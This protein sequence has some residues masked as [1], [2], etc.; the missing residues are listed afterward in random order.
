MVVIA[1]LI[2][3]GFKVF[4][5]TVFYQQSKAAQKSYNNSFY[6]KHKVKE[7]NNP[8]IMFYNSE[9]I[10]YSKDF[11]DADDIYS[12]FKADTKKDLA[13]DCIYYFVYQYES[14]YN[15]F[16]SYRNNA[17]NL[18][19]NTESKIE[20]AKKNE[21]F[22][23]R[24]F[25]TFDSNIVNS[26]VNDITESPSKTQPS[27]CN[28]TKTV[29]ELYELF[30]PIYLDKYI[31]SSI[32]NRYRDRK[33]SKKEMNWFN[34][35]KLKHSLYFDNLAKENLI[36]KEADAKALAEK[37]RIKEKR[38]IQKIED[39]QTGYYQAIQDNKIPIL[40]AIWYHQ[41]IEL[42]ILIADG[43]DLNIKDRFGRTPLFI[44]VQKENAYALDLLLKQ[45]ANMYTLDKHELYIPFTQ[46]IFSPNPDMKMVQIFL[47][48]DIN[49]NFK[50]KYNTPTLSF[51]IQGCT[52][53]ELVKLLIDEGAKIKD[54]E[55]ALVAECP[56]KDKTHKLRTLLESQKR[57]FFF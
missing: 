49:L 31:S 54:I 15:N 27:I 45:G 56:D 18:Y 37:N 48:H 33:P 17:R 43:A 6:I 51:A 14:S 32:H 8:K 11:I 46:L 26:V 39:D 1:I 38:R 25:Y 34:V 10:K 35:L 44:A 55:T 29:D 30:I 50:N 40:A 47:D 41:N 36:K 2:V 23:S 4:V 5:F 52:N 13:L 12:K 24:N 22:M 42:D 16:S 9:L 28:D 20:K 7:Y 19:A 53:F 3:I 21:R 57:F